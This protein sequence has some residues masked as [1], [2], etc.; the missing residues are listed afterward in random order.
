MYFKI[1]M[2]IPTFLVI[3]PVIY[4]KVLQT[5]INKYVEKEA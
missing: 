4:S 2:K 5:M 3:H 1:V